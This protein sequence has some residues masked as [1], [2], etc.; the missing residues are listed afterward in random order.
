[1][2]GAVLFLHVESLSGWCSQLQ[3][4]QLTTS[5]E[6][7]DKNLFLG[8]T[9][10]TFPRGVLCIVAAPAMLATKDFAELEKEASE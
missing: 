7:G 10:T 5:S 8:G 3:G 6:D 2:D 9:Y 1:M 4:E